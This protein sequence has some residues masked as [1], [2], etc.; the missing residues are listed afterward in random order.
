MVR[1]VQL[2]KLV[3]LSAVVK[4]SVAGAGFALAALASIDIAIAQFAKD[5]WDAW[6]VDDLIS[7]FALIGAISGMVLQIIK[8]IILR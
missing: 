2:N 4:A 7:Q 6:H 8:L 3:F 1:L 5:A